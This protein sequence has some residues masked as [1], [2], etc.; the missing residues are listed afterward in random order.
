MA[1]REQDIKQ[2]EDL[3]TPTRKISI[4]NVPGGSTNDNPA[5]G[6]AANNGEENKA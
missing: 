6:G 3:L 1:A 5:F 4:S 2:R